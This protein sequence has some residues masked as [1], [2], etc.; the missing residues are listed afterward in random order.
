M[1][2]FLEGE[3]IVRGKISVG[4]SYSFVQASTVSLD[5]CLMRRGFD[6]DLL[7]P[8]CLPLVP[9]MDVVGHVCACGSKVNP[10]FK[11]GDRVAALVRTGGNARFISVAS[12]SLVKVP[13]NVDSAEAV[14]MV[15]TFT[16]AY[17]TLKRIKQTGPMFSLLGKRVL[18]I[19]GLNGVGQALIQMCVKARAE[20][21]APCPHNQQ[22]Y[23]LNVLGAHP[24][25]E[26][27]DQWLPLMVGQVD[28]VFDGVCEDGLETSHKALN[29]TGEIICFGHAAMLKDRE[30]GLFGAPLSA[31][32][33]RCTRLMDARRN[34]NYFFHFSDTIENNLDT[35]KQN[36]EF[37]KS[38]C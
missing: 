1:H 18:V 23:L 4:S 17:Q 10:S 34:G 35:G 3:Y 36:V 29:D 21:F 30:I 14:A 7:N 9:G 16:T 13:K 28:F 19:G 32:V 22:A 33:S 24:L 27:K 20:I 25:P 31:H 6:F 37:N 26:D 8:V 12:S 15:A 5:D 38:A 2:P 11:E